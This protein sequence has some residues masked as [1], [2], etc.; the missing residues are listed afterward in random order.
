MRLM[1]D[2]LGVLREALRMERDG[3]WTSYWLPFAAV[4]RALRRPL[5]LSR[6]RAPV[7]FGEGAS[8]AAAFDALA[9]W[10][11]LIGQLIEV[12][13]PAW[14]LALRRPVDI[15]TAGRWERV[16]V[17]QCLCFEAYAVLTTEEIDRTWQCLETGEPVPRGRPSDRI[18]FS[19]HWH[20][21]A[22]EAGNDQPYG[23]LGLPI[24]ALAR[25]V[26]G[27]CPE[28]V[29]ADETGVHPGALAQAVP[30]LNPA[31]PFVRSRL[32]G[33]ERRALDLDVE[34][35]APFGDAVIHGL[36]NALCPARTPERADREWRETE[37]AFKVSD[38]LD[39]QQ[40]QTE[41]DDHGE[42]AGGT[43]EKRPMKVRF[44]PGAFDSLIESSERESRLAA[45]VLDSLDA[46][47]RRAVIVE[48]EE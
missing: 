46:I 19:G 44:A 4:E 11:D 8:V 20:V 15:D 26:V 37:D 10:G 39:D 45:E 38:A 40:A 3:C 28:T 42:D 16:V 22:Y 35:A 23:L 36:L 30:V 1:I 7:V 14:W 33:D 25:A 21:S 31:S 13:F 5:F 9:P 27:I 32:F 34:T 29:V 2:R 6:L 41:E 43:A 12:D 47:E 17:Q 48:T 24:A 18:Q